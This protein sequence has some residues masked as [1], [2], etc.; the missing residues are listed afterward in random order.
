[1]ALLILR[2]IALARLLRSETMNIRSAVLAL[3]VAICSLA[4]GAAQGVKPEKNLLEN[5]DFSAGIIHW[6]GDG[7]AEVFKSA[8]GPDA[9]KPPDGAATPAPARPPLGSVLGKPGADADRSYCVTLG[10]RP[11]KFAQSFSVPRNT[12]VLKI[13]FRAR[14]GD[15][16]LTSRTTLGAFQ[17]HLTPPPGSGL[18]GMFDDKKLERTPEWQTFTIDWTMSGYSR[19]IEL[20]VEVFPGTGQLYFDDFVIEA[21]ER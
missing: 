15:G 3:V 11:Q 6:K 20:S 18:G 1:M 4:S 5:G 16:F 13:R 10:T 21:L 8:T 19:N 14:T 7:K 2:C 12:K 17:V 9:T